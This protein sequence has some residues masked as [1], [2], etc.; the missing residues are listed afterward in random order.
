MCYASS[1]PPSGHRTA[2]PAHAARSARGGLLAVAALLAACSGPD[3][4][5]RSEGFAE[6]AAEGGSSDGAVYFDVTQPDGPPPLD[7]PGLCGNF[8]FK[9]APEPPNLYFVLDRS[10]SMVDPS[11]LPGMTRYQAVRAA[12]IDVVRTLGSR[13]NYGVTLFPGSPMGNGCAAGTEVFKTAPGDPEGSVAGPVTTTIAKVTQITPMGGTPTSA[14]LEALLPR[15]QNLTGKT[16][17][18]LATDGGPNC[19]DKFAC[20]ASDCTYT[21]EGG[22][23]DGVPCTLQYNCCDPDVANGPGWYMCLDSV[24]TIQ[25]VQALRGAGIRTFVVG[26]PGSAYYET[27]LDQLATIGG[28]ARPQ[29]PHYYRVDDLGGLAQ[30]LLQIG[31]KV[32]VT[33]TFVLEQVPP[34]PDFVNVY[35]DTEVVAYDEQNGWT[36]TGETTLVLHGEACKKL[37]DGWVG[38]VQVVAGCPTKQPL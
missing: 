8:L 15:L 28:S 37:E 33:C 18:V 10:G 24:P 7:A 14:T 23:I 20:S 38:Q 16:A 26:I 5:A 22:S 9:V 27:L 25:A 35:F 1:V 6:P 36:W 21:I 3:R 34:D 31:D 2:E 19:N 30:T 13:A 17:V 4:A 29:S 11:G 12:V 32:L